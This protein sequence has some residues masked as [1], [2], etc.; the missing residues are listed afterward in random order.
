MR[1]FAHK[2][3]D[4]R[5]VDPGIEQVLKDAGWG[6]LYSLF[7]FDQTNIKN[8]DALLCLAKEDYVKG[9]YSG[10][11]YRNDDSVGFWEPCFVVSRIG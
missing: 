1:L 3:E 8:N 6:K 2:Y 4:S 10:S 11:S 5:E 7:S 9:E